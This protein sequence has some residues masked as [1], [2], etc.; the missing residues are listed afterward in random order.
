VEGFVDT[1]QEV[2]SKGYAQLDPTRPAEGRF[3]GRWRVQVNV[4]DAE[5]T[6][7]MEE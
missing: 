6:G 2:L 5:L 7:W 3:D 4:S 1:W